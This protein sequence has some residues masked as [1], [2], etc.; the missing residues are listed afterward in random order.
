MI[1][2]PRQ[3][4]LGQIVATLAALRA[5]ESLGTESCGLR[6]SP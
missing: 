3:F 6:P 4:S 1:A 2:I 5:I